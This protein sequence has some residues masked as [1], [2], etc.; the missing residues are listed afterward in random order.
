MPRLTPA[1]PARPR[2]FM[3]LRYKSFELVSLMCSKIERLKPRRYG[4]VSERTELAKELRKAATYSGLA[5]K[6][7]A[8]ATDNTWFSLSMSIALFRRRL[9]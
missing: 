4:S 7:T 3:R 8:S 6:S 1:P 5:M 9:R 2:T